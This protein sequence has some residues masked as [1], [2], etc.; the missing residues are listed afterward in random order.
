MV[1]SLFPRIEPVYC[2]L[3]SAEVVHGSDWL[4]FSD[5]IFNFGIIVPDFCFCSPCTQKVIVTAFSY[6]P[7]PFPSPFVSQLNV[8][9]KL[10]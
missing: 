4:L 2:L 9:S 7:F 8:W 5:L 3:L 6:T 10:P 1:L